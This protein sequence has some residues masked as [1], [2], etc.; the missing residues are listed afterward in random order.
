MVD[1]NWIY[2]LLNDITPLPVDCGR[3]CGSACC[4]EWEKGVGMY[5]LP[6]EEIMFE[7]GEQWLIW[8]ERFTGDDHFYPGRQETLNFV[9]CHGTCPRNKRPFA[10]RTFPVSPYLTSRGELQLRLEESAV[11]ICPLVKSGDIQLLDRRFMVR[12]RLAWEELLRDPLIRDG[13]ERES[14]RLDRIGTEPWQ[15]LLTRD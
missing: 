15:K 5:L 11:L 6:G 13:V 10:C 4:R 1:W 2:K 8:E 3:L 14:R 7:R 12:V 9:R